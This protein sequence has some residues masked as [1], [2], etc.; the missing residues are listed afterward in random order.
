MMAPPSTLYSAVMVGNPANS[1][2]RLPTNSGEAVGSIPVSADDDAGVRSKTPH[3]GPRPDTQEDALSGATSTAHTGCSGSATAGLEI[4]SRMRTTSDITAIILTGGR[5]TRFGA[6]KASAQV[7]GATM[8]D[9]ILADIPL[10]VP[11][12][13]VGPDLE[14]AAQP[15]PPSRPRSR[16]REPET[17]L[18]QRSRSL[19]VTHE[20]PAGGGPVAGVLAGL[21]LVTTPICCVIATDMPTSASVAL[22]LAAEHAR[23]LGSSSDPAKQTQEGRP[24]SGKG[25][26]GQFNAAQLRSPGGQPVRSPADSGPGSNRHETLTA[27]D[28]D[29]HAR[30]PLK[31]Q[32]DSHVP[33]ALI[34]L[35]VGGHAQPLCASYSTDALRRAA[36]ALGSG[37]HAS[38]RNLLRLLRVRQVDLEER[39]RR[40]LFDIDTRDDLDRSGQAIMIHVGGG[41]SLPNTGGTNMLND[42][43]AAAASEL[44]LDTEVD[45]DVI[46]DVAKEAAHGVAR[47]AAPLTTF[48]LGYAVAKG[49]DLQEA[50][51]KVNA[52]ADAWPQNQ[53]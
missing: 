16:T 39:D 32:P 45:V 52:L 19:I 6:D 4:D 31:R 15:T 42:W 50:A 47:P 37:H 34:P 48:L 27:G 36:T 2:D 11:V 10:S 38:V 35:D 23:Q 20:E 17:G 1:A 46:L 33:E 12:V 53:G 9:H 44:N 22:G 30:T 14:Q 40:K 7:A 21:K 8:L 24:T 41:T 49:A 29:G 5:S 43:A 13:L 25:E 26:G 18:D 3:R 28:P 51:A